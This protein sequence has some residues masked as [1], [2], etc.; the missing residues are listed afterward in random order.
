MP[1]PF[2]ASEQ[3]LSEWL[4]EDFEE[5]ALSVLR[6]YY[7][8][9]E[10]MLED[11]RSHGESGRDGDAV[12]VIAEGQSDVRYKLWV[13]IKKRTGANLDVDDVSGHVLLA[14]VAD[15]N[16][17]VFVANCSYT[18][19]LRSALGEFAFRCGVDFTLMTCGDLLDV[20]R[21]IGGVREPRTRS[22]G[23][24]PDADPPAALAGA[25]SL[26]TSEPLIVE[27]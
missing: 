6:Q 22:A 24:E 13:E 12:Y 18:D 14:F 15:V 26:E 11:K 2:P 23:T 10:V 21:R 16:R 8:I 25:P 7:G 17:L 20:A 27:V 1:R 9:H 5:F 19:A 4:W 3:E